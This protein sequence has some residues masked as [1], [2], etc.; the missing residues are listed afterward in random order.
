MA[1]DDN[2]SKYTTG[3]SFWLLFERYFYTILMAFS[4]KTSYFFD[5]IVLDNPIE[6]ICAI[7]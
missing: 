3:K 2:E 5:W 7:L 4:H 1:Q 6:E